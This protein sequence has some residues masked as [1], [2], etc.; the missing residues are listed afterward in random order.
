[1]LATVLEANASKNVF[2]F[3]IMVGKEV[4][5]TSTKKNFLRVIVSN[6]NINSI[7]DYTHSG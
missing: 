2:G 5:S 4:R 1:M 6:K 3:E 7:C